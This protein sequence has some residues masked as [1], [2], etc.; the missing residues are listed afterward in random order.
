[1]RFSVGNPR[2][3]ATLVSV[4]TLV[5]FTASCQD[6][7]PAEPVRS[8]PMRSLRI[9]LIPESNIFSQKKRYEPIAKYLSA[10]IHANVE[11]VILSRY[12]NII[13]NFVSNRLDGAFFGSFTGALAHRKLH[14][15]AIARPEYP[16]G[17]STYHGL[18][19]VR[20]DSG[21]T[22]VED[23]EGKRFAFVDKATT[24]GYLL[25]LYYFKTHG[26]NDANALLQETYFTGT[27]ES[28]IRDVLERKA[29]I[30]AAKNTMFSRLAS[31]D[32]RIS[33]ELSILTRSPD[34]PENALCVRADL[35]ESLKDELRIALLSMDRDDIGEKILN[36]FGAA[37]FIDT[38]EEDYSAVFEYAETIGLDLENY[39][40][41]ND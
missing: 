31:T 1:M 21:I 12:G 19:F 3:G 26:I 8:E 18:I 34:V 32:P 28:A 13:D 16:D 38:T 30:G 20:K 7:E 39:D 11:L 22:K 23:M 33:E 4:L 15:E 29:D 40:Y 2:L 41:L 10:H 35:D 27:H 25:P 17:T 36:S 24:A 9:G 14:V 37:R 5:V 6:R